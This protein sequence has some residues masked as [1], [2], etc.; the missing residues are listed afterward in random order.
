METES[1]GP[2]V[3]LASASGNTLG[4][5]SDEPTTGRAAP[6]APAAPFTR[7]AR[8][9]L[10]SVQPSVYAY[11]ALG[12]LLG[13]NARGG[14]GRARPVR[15]LFRKKLDPN[16][17]AETS[18]DARLQPFPSRQQKSAM[19]SAQESAIP[20]AQD[21]WRWGWKE[22]DPEHSDSRDGKPNRLLNTLA[23]STCRQ[24]RKRSGKAAAVPLD[25]PY[26]TRTRKTAKVNG[27][28]KGDFASKGGKPT[29][30]TRS[31]IKGEPVATAN[32]VEATTAGAYKGQREEYSELLR[33]IEDLF[34]VSTPA[35]RETALGLRDDL[36]ILSS[37]EEGLQ[38]SEC[39]AIATKLALAS[40]NNMTM[41]RRILQQLGSTYDLAAGDTEKAGRVHPATLCA[42][43][44]LSRDAVG[45]GLLKRLAICRSGKT[46]NQ[47]EL[48]PELVQLHDSWQAFLKARDAFEEAVATQ[49]GGAAEL[50]TAFEAAETE[51]RTANTA[52]RQKEYG[53][54]PRFNAYRNF[55]EAADTVCQRDNTTMGWALAKI[56]ELIR[57]NTSPTTGDSATDLAWRVMCASRTALWYVENPGREGPNGQS[58]YKKDEEGNDVEKSLA[59]Y[60]GRKA[61]LDYFIWN[62]GYRDDGPKSEFTRMMAQLMKIDKYAERG[63]KRAKSRRSAFDPRRLL[64]KKKSP[65]TAMSGK[66]YNF[67]S[68]LARDD[69]KAYNKAL[70]ELGAYRA[71]QL[72][73]KIRKD[74]RDTSIDL[75]QTVVQIAMLRVLKADQEALDKGKT[76]KVLDQPL[77][78]PVARP[79]I[80]KEIDTVLNEFK[81]PTQSEE[82]PQREAINID[83]VNREKIN[84]ILEEGDDSFFQLTHATVREWLPK[85]AQ[86]ADS[87]IDERQG[88][89]SSSTETD[90][91]AKLLKNIGEKAPEDLDQKTKDRLNKHAMVKHFTHL[92]WLEQ[93]GEQ[94]K[95]KSKNHIYDFMIRAVETMRNNS[96]TGTEGAELGIDASVVVPV[97]PGLTLRPRLATTDTRSAAITQSRNLN[98]LAITVAS[99]RGASHEAGLDATIGVDSGVAGLGGMIGV[100]AGMGKTRSKG[101]T[102]RFKTDI[103]QN[104]QKPES[105]D[106]KKPKT[107]FAFE[108]LKDSEL[109][110]GKGELPDMDASRVGMRNF[111]RFMKKFGNGEAGKPEGNETRLQGF[112]TAF[113]EEF[114]ETRTL[115]LTGT[116][117]AN[118]TVQITTREMLGLRLGTPETRAFIGIGSEQQVR[119]QTKALKENSLRAAANNGETELY[120]TARAVAGVTVTPALG[121]KDAK[122]PGLNGLSVQATPKEESINVQ[123]KLQMKDGQL[124]E[125][126]T[127]RIMTTRNTEA[128]RTTLAPDLAAWHQYTSGAPT[129]QKF[130]DRYSVADK[131]DNSMFFQRIENLRKPAVVKIRNYDS[132]ISALEIALARARGNGEP[133]RAKQLEK[134]I[135][136]LRHARN[137]VLEDDNS[138]KAYSLTA[139]QYIDRSSNK[140]MRFGIVAQTKSSKAVT[141][142]I[143]WFSWG[144]DTRIKQGHKM[145]QRE[146]LRERVAQL[147]LKNAEQV[148][149]DLVRKYDELAAPASPAA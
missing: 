6:A 42:A 70:V 116:R 103:V 126:C 104:E 135:L 76:P 71:D 74:P 133:A 15:G 112:M 83:H 147:G 20:S 9:A 129:L 114:L 10:K 43:Q 102:V 39:E 134:R 64:G 90:K 73:N 35:G 113:A 120:A 131:G 52:W 123:I 111:Y 108:Q 7:R 14:A 37:M 118:R 28:D 124:D 132:Q 16:F 38:G 79:R 59:E 29:R 125:Y 95:P 58:A 148:F 88:K 89:T 45:L 78:G 54:E 138:W 144:L 82:R 141:E 91:L 41:A 142:E 61:T 128:L 31:D 92:Q 22:A 30:H 130:L 72:D 25:M 48:P 53:F 107:K 62:Q 146:L 100:T 23:D 77:Q 115:E 65:F 80:A 3:S 36:L 2:R 121:N 46:G 145:E 5:A 85:L 87:L 96:L 18:K 24:I 105:Q 63:V 127:F 94:L 81:A 11:S 106:E 109:R 19:P 101:T 98:G 136:T 51:W 69:R 26:A 32:P 40:G 122:L 12:G 67:Q 57:F 17:E 149:N 75:E 99:T 27:T 93:G 137:A 44:L 49:P 110:N 140:G 97:A 34:D 55:L 84:A 86:R 50:K 47:Q 8:T 143:E 60:L 117:Q 119:A 21:R 1:I 13:G 56:S 33:N 66:T 68:Q 139:R 4:R